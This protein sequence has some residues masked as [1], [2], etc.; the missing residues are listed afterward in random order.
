MIEHRFVQ[1]QFCDDIRHEVSNKFSLIGCYAA[2]LIVDRM[3]ALLPKLCMQV[4]ISTPITKRFQSLKIK[5]LINHE[6]LAELEVP[7]EAL[8]ASTDPN[9][10]EGATRST[11]AAVMVLSPFAVAEPG[12]LRVEV[13]T[14]SETLVGNRLWLRTLSPSVGRD[15][16]A[17]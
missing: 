9:A 1:V 6:L 15:V 2:D 8:A 5:T 10:P 16:L 7:S 4:L 13:E 17:T 14:E 12:L 3:P 11:I